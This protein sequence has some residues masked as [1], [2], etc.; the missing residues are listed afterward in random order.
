M[1]SLTNQDNPVK[2]GQPQPQPPGK[3]EE[4]G[5]HG[6]GGGQPKPEIPDIPEEVPKREIDRKPSDP[7][8][9]PGGPEQGPKKQIPDKGES[10]ENNDVEEQDPDLLVEDDRDTGNKD[11]ESLVDSRDRFPFPNKDTPYKKNKNGN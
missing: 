6:E 10:E 1:N 3:E 9:V 2:P 4:K 8:A 5:R 7:K 11:P